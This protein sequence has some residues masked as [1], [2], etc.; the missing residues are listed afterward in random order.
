M[1]EDLP[2][3]KRGAKED[4]HSSSMSRG[5]T[6]SLNW[7]EAQPHL[8]HLSDAMEEEVQRVRA[9]HAH[10]YRDFLIQL[11]AP[12]DL[13]NHKVV[14]SAGM[15]SCSLDINGRSVDDFRHHRTPLVKLLEEIEQAL[16]W[17]WASHLDKMRIA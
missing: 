12:H 10:N 11:L 3:I 1:I 16:D 5:S 9:R 14:I 6:R 4:W 17:D 15:G 13:S 7:V 8:G 2:H